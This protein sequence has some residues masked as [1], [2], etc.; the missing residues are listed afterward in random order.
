ME[1]TKLSHVELARELERRGIK[2]LPKSKHLMLAHA[3]CPRC[4]YR[5]PIERDFGTR[6]LRGE[7]VPQSWCRLCRAGRS[8]Q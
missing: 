3:E 5:G 1:L 6:V 7:V 2:K 8:V 4:H